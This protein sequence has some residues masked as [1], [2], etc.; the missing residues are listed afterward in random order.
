MKVVI[1]SSFNVLP[2][3]KRCRI[4]VPRNAKRSSIYLKTNKERSVRE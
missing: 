4:V 3:K 2:V 1:S